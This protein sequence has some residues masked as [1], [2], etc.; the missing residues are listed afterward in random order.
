MEVGAASARTV[1]AAVREMREF[2][3][4]A[5]ETLFSVAP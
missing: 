1:P 4:P 5:K 3:N 2:S